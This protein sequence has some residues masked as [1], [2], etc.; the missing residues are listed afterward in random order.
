MLDLLFPSDSEDGEGVRQIRIEDCGSQPR[1]G[2]VEVQGVPANGIIDSGADITIIDGDL[3][4]RVAAVARLKKKN[5][6]KA[7][8]GPWTYD[9]RPFS[10]DGKMDLDISFGDIT[11]K[12]PMYVKIDAPEP[13]LLSEGVCRQLGLISYHPSLTKGGSKTRSAPRT[14]PPQVRGKEGDRSCPNHME[15]SR[16][17][18]NQE[19]KSGENVK[20]EDQSYKQPYRREERHP[21]VA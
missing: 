4:R 20:S 19:G 5:L 11:M 16:Q 10:L 14:S 8:R 3:F 18:H 12:T 2:Q 6:R 17:P 1:Y 15:P 13:L 9:R 7:D 21:Q